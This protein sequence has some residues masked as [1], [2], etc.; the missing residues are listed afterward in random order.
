MME[1][2]ISIDI[3][4]SIWKYSTPIYGK[5]LSSWVIEVLLTYEARCLNKPHLLSHSM[6]EKAEKFSSEVRIEQT[7][8]AKPSQLY[9]IKIFIEVY[10]EQLGKTRQ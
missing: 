7:F 8:S 3:L 4:K 6:A 1:K 9:S 10:P 2:I 5:K